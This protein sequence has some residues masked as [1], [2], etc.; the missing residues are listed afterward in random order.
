MSF[1]PF[2]ETANRNMLH[3]HSLTEDFGLF[4]EII[5]SPISF[6]TIHKPCRLLTSYILKRPEFTFPQFG[7]AVAIAY[8]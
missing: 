1:V 3:N 7:T 4:R 2:Q 8:N 6:M 5:L